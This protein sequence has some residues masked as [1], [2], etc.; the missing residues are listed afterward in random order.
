MKKH[1][2][3]RTETSS[4]R[5]HS[6]P[7]VDMSS[8]FLGI[9][10]LLGGSAVDGALST[11]SGQAT[12][13]ERQQPETGRFRDEGADAGGAGGA[14]AAG[15]RLAEV[16]GEVVEVQRVDDAVEVE[17]GLRPDFSGP[18]EVAGQ[19]VEIQRINGAVE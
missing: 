1:E 13:G 14:A 5:V 3:T 4:C 15:Q 19:G 7:S 18:A 10:A 8:V 9:S 11:T 12:R 16:G 17:V 6:C 2:W